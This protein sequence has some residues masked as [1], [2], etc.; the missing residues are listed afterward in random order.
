[1]RKLA[2]FLFA[3]VLG[4]LS[5][6]TPVVEQVV[7]HRVPQPPASIPAAAQIEYLLASADLLQAQAAMANAQAQLRAAVERQNAAFKPL[8]ELCGEFTLQK[9]P[10]GKSL[11]CA[12][13]PK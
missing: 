3:A 12:A 4:V 1:M 9:A 10:D 8:A 11:V 5:G 2:A 6:Q 13:K 7:A